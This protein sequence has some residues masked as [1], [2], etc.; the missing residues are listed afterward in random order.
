MKKKSLVASA[1][2][3]VAGSLA[4]ATL[5]LGGLTWIDSLGL[6]GP[7]RLLQSRVKGYWEARLNGDLEA[8]AEYVH[9]QQG[10]V[11]DPGMLITEGYQLHGIELDGDTAT[12]MLTVQSRLQHPMFSERGREVELASKWVRYEGKWYLDIQPIGIHETIQHYV[13]GEVKADDNA[14]AAQ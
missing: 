13:R 3:L 10:S 12:A 5:A 8:M 9:P 2:I 7:E 1:S 11:I 6:R 4:A 14:Q